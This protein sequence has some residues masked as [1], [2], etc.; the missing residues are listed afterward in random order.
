MGRDKINCVVKLVSMQPG[1][2]INTE[3]AMEVHYARSIEHKRILPLIASIKHGD[4][5]YL[6][7]PRMKCDLK[8][9]LPYIVSLKSRLIIALEIAEGISY[10]HSRGIVH[11]DIKAPNILLDDGNHVKIAD[12]GLCK[13]EAMMNASIVGTPLHMPPE[14]SLGVRYDKS[15]DVYAFGI[16]LWFIHDGTGRLPQNLIIGLLMCPPMM[17]ALG[18]RPERLSHFNEKLWSLMEECW[19]PDHAKRPS[20]DIITKDLQSIIRSLR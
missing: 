5:V 3:I 10:L 12:L 18:F 14:V 2:H 15:V 1:V 9:A 7:S 17:S 4:H 13:A 19:Q 6:V 20:F 16:L 8:E 11:R